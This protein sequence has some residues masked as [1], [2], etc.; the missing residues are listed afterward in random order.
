MASMAFRGER[1][2]LRHGMA[3][4]CL[5]AFVLLQVDPGLSPLGYSLPA[6]VRR[7]GAW[8]HTSTALLNLYVLIY[9]MQADSIGYSRLEDE[10]RVALAQR[11]FE[12]HYQPLVNSEGRVVGAEALLRW[13]HPRRGLV[14]PGSF[15]TLAEQTG[16]I[17]PIGR[18][19]LE[20]ACAQLQV[21]ARYRTTRHLT[22]AVNISQ[23][24]FRD[25][26]FV[27]QVLR[28]IERYNI[29]A[30]RLE[31][32]LTESIL[33]NDVQDIVDKM[34][35]L[36][37]RGVRLSLDD[38]GTGFSSLS[39]LKRLPFNK[40]KIDQSFVRDILVDSHDAA[41]V[42]T[43]V[44]LGQSLNLAVLA[45]GVESE[46]QRQFLL[47]VGCELFQGYLYSPALPIAAFNSFVLQHNPL[48]AQ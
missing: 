21:W 37:D 23:N 1:P 35:A 41:I 8:A 18:W 24:Q 6:D 34:S 27:Q 7:I 5:L 19:A 20:V 28:L 33:V 9:F 2:W 14:L 45:E 44:A 25:S 31:L 15:I 12:L 32:E 29:D 36:R 47:K 16:L 17:L 46:G 22:L 48:L 38:F 42:R 30:S 43:V 3:A 39:Y 11:E 13:Q 4:I 10:L 40:I 26:D